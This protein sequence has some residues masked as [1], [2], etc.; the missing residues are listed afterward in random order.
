MSEID[1]VLEIL[2]IERPPLGVAN[3][4]SIR[5]RGWIAGSLSGQPAL[6]AAQAD[7]AFVGEFCK[8]A[9]M[10]QLLG[11]QLETVSLRQTGIVMPT[12]RGVRA[13]LVSRPSPRSGHTNPLS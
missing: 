12:H 1:R 5:Q 2:R 11:N 3:T 8:D 4:A 9:A 7:S 13:G 6:S 10:L